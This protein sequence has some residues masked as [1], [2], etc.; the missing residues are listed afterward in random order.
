[1]LAIA[2]APTAARDAIGFTSIHSIFR[3]Y[4]VTEVSH[5]ALS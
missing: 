4:E 5:R 1:M 2:T 3:L